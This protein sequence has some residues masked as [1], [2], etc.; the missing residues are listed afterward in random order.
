[1]KRTAMLLAA[2]VILASCDGNPFGAGG[3]D[4]GAVNP[5]PGTTNP[6]AGGAIKRYEARS[7]TQ[8]DGFVSAV[9][10]NEGDDTFFVDGLA[11]DGDNVYARSTAMPSL[12]AGATN[13]RFRVYDGPMI[14]VD[15]ATGA[16]IPQ[17]EH[18][19]LYGVSND[20]N[21][22]FAIARTGNYIP[23]GFGGFV[24]QRNTGIGG[25]PQTGQALFS[26]DYAGIRDFD[27]VGGL[28][29]VSGTMNVAIDFAD[30]NSNP[31]NGRGVRGEVTNRSVFDINGNDITANILTALSASSGVTQTELPTLL[32]AV[33]PGTMDDN[34]EMSGGAQSSV[35][36]ST[37]GRTAFE[38][39]NYYAVLSGNGTPGG[40]QVV[41]VIVVTSED[42]RTAGVTARETGG[43]IVHRRP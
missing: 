7:D 14:A 8:G 41:G 11:F 31:T 16:T 37:G 13:A 6:T 43:F 25:L 10:Y 24:Y 1:M 26:G 40:D 27:G 42:P 22:E 2:A 21:V 38:A 9:R 12:R 4:G 17:F 32:F 23:Y 18:R 3:D 33:G 36:N 35:R 30:F 20:G 39:G 29:Y 28:E 5:L 34:G 19:A 15:P